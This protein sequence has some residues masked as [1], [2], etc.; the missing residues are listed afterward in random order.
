[1]TLFWLTACVIGGDKYPRPRDLADAWQVD[2]TRVLA[3]VAEPPE[4]RPGETATFSALI[5]HAAGEAPDLGVLWIACPVEGDGS[6]FG[7]ATDLGSVDL[8]GTPTPDELAELGV[9]GFEPGFPPVYAAPADLLE[10]LPAEERLEGTYVLV[11]VTAFPLDQ[12]DEPVDEIDFGEVEAAYKRLVVSEAPTPNANPVI[13]A[14]TVDGT[15]VPP[16]ALVHVD[17][18]QVYDVSLE[19]GLGARE[20]YEYVNRDGETEDRVEEPYISWFVSGTDADASGDPGGE[21]LEAVTLWP[22]LDASWLSPAERGSTGTWFAVLRDR[23][24]GMAWWRQDWVVD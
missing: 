1:M 21:L 2:R 14:G 12:L 23:R 18:D 15:A 19:L 8:S 17:A 20:R 11:Q 7:C 6:G 3:V 5:A 13:A 10:P 9:V 4:V 16:G 24:G 22:Y